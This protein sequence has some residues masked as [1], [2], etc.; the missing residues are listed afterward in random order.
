ML[1]NNHLYVLSILLGLTLL[2]TG[3]AQGDTEKAAIVNGETILKEEFDNYLN[4]VKA[5]YAQQGLDLDA[6]ENMDMLAQL[7][8]QLLDDMIAK[9]LLLAEAEKEEIE[10]S[11]ETVEEEVELLREQL[12][13]EQFEEILAA[14]NLTEA[15]LQRDIADQL[16]I[17]RLLELRIPE[18]ELVVTDEEI[19]QYFEQLVDSWEG[20]DAE[21]SVEDLRPQIEQSL[22]A[23]KYER[24]VMD[25]I[26]KLR[27]EA[28]VEIFI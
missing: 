15:D 4:S 27:A 28:D 7:E 24:A 23:E 2:L 26:E 14:E 18:K 10:I 1:K 9:T 19:A 8:G 25:F 12:G 11:R 3:C 17:E 20:D 22:Q 5:S 13:A 6:E 21:Q 16:R